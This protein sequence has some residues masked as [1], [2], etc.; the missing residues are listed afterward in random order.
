M[1]H[2]AQQDGFLPDTPQSLVRGTDTGQAVHLAHGLK[3]GFLLR[4]QVNQSVC[5]IADGAVTD[6]I[7]VSKQLETSQKGSTPPVRGSC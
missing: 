7:F 1:V 3:S 5:S 2:I 4:G 6:E